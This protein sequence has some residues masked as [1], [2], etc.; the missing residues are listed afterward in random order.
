MSNQLAKI[1]DEKVF[2]ISPLRVYSDCAGQPLLEV[3][4]NQETLNLIGA[5]FQTFD[6]LATLGYLCGN[7]LKRL[8]ADSMTRREVLQRAKDFEQSEESG[9]S[10]L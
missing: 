7:I 8:C 9:F 5:T 10:D 4:L 6:D 2:G 3:P 1:I